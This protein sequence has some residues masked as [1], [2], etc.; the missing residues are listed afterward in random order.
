MTDGIIGSNILTYTAKIELERLPALIGKRQASDF[1]SR[2]IFPVSMQ[3]LMRW[4]PPRKYVGGRTMFE[5]DVIIGMALARLAAAPKRG[6][7]PSRL[8]KPAQSTTG[9][10]Q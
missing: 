8:K 7:A 5:R 1:I 6:P 2:H 9:A 3:T 4:D 10:N